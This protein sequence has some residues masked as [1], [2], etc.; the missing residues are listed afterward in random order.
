MVPGRNIWTGRVGNT[1]LANMGLTDSTSLRFGSPSRANCRV[2]EDVDFTLSEQVQTCGGCH[3]RR[4]ELQ[5]RDIAS[6]FLNNYSLSPLLEGLYH[7]DGQIQDEVY[8]L[9]SFLQ[10]KMHA[11]S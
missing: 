4:A 6:D 1:E 5:Q 3:A 8:V 7:A 9:G 2:P 11:Q 10:S